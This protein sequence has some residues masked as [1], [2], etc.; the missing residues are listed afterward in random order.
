MFCQDPT[1]TLAAPNSSPLD[2]GFSPYQSNSF[3]PHVVLPKNQQLQV[4]RIRGLG[5]LRSLWQVDRSRLRNVTNS[6]TTASQ[7]SADWIRLIR[8]QM[9]PQL[10]IMRAIQERAPKRLKQATGH[11][12]VDR[13]H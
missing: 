6:C 7:L 10:S 1:A 8:L 5:Y 4:V 2:P 13:V 9:M 11:V 12:P 3:E